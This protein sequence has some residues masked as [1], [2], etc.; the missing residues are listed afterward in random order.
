M[1]QGI[2]TRGQ[3]VD[4]FCHLYRTVNS[5]IMKK[6]MNRWLK[7]NHY[8]IKKSVHKLSVVTSG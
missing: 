5:P 2:K 3:A 7:Y 1:A 4:T 8:N 6:F